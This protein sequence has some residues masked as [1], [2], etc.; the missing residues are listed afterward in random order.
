MEQIPR[1]I[2]G[3]RRPGSAAFGRNGG[4]AHVLNR[5]VRC[6]G[7]DIDDLLY[8]GRCAEPRELCPVEL[9]LLSS[10]ELIEIE[11]DPDAAESRAA[12]L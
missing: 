3:R 4:L 5:F 1:V 11:S 12:T 9:N 7:P 2:T 6:V 8:L 10:D